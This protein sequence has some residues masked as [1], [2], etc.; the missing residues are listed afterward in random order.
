M[1]QILWSGEYVGIWIEVGNNP[2]GLI[3]HWGQWIYVSSS[4]VSHTN[5]IHIVFL[6]F[7][8]LGP[9]KANGP[10]LSQAGAWG[11]P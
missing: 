5:Q 2:T 3:H 1:T 4:Y 6:K 11:F 7:F 10:G 8:T 9:L